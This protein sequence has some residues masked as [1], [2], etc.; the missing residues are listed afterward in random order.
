MV[1]RMNNFFL[2]RRS[3]IK[4]IFQNIW[5]M[6]TLKSLIMFNESN[7]EDVKITDKNLFALGIII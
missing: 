1:G 5:V 7:N 6:N 2:I 3:C 4:F